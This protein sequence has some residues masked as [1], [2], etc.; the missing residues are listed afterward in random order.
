[1]KS[2]LDKVVKAYRDSQ[3]LN[4][5]KEEEKVIVD[6]ADIFRAEIADEIE[7]FKEELIGALDQRVTSIKS[8]DLSGIEKKLKENKE[9]RPKVN[10]EKLIAAI[11]N[12]KTVIS[13]ERVEGLTDT[14]RIA[15]SNAVP[16]TTTFVNGIRAKNLEF[17]TAAVSYL[18]DKAIIDTG[19]SGDEDL[20]GIYIVGPTGSGADYETDGTADDVQ[21]NEAIVAANLAGGGVVYILPGEYTIS[22]IIFILSNVKL[23]GSGI[24]ITTIKSV[25][26][27]N[28]PS[29]PVIGSAADGRIQL[30]GD[31]ATNIHISGITWDGN[32]QN[33]SGLTNNTHG[34]TFYITEAEDLFIK[35]NKFINTIHY[36][37]Y[38]GSSTNVWVENNIVLGG[39]DSTYV[40]ND[41]VLTQNCDYV[42][43]RG[44]FIDTVAGGG[45]SGDS[46]IVA[47]CT[48][49][50]HG[51][52]DISGNIISSRIAGIELVVGLD[53]LL[54]NVNV[55]DNTILY[56][57]AAGITIHKYDD[58]RLGRIINCTIDNNIIDNY[59][60]SGNGAITVIQETSVAEAVYEQLTITNNTC[61]TPGATTVNGIN[62]TAKGTSLKIDGNQ[63]KNFTG[64]Y[65]IVV[66]GTSR[67]VKDYSVCNNIID[68]SLGAS[69]GRGITVLGGERG[70]IS[71]NEIYGHTT[72]TTYAI[73]LAEGATAG[74]DNDGVPNIE[75][76]AYNIVSNNQIYNV[77]NGIAE[78]NAGG[79]P[80]DNQFIS[81]SFNTVTT[82]YTILS[83]TSRIFH[84]NSQD[85]FW[86]ANQV[87]ST[88]LTSLLGSG[89]IATSV[90]TGALVI[91]SESTG[92]S[93]ASA[94]ALYGLYSNDGAALASGDRMG[95]ILLGGSSSASS[96]RNSASVEGFT[97]QAWSDGSA[98]GSRLQFFTTNNGATSRTSKM[99]I[100]NDGATTIGTSL[101]TPI[102]IGGTGTTSTLTIQST[103]GAGTT[104]AD[105]L[106]K[107]GNN[108]ATEA[109]RI[110]NS[111]FFGIGEAAPQ[112]ILHVTG[113][114]A[115][116][117]LIPF[118]IKN[119][120]TSDNTATSIAFNNSTSTSTTAKI[121]AIRL[122]SSGNNDLVFSV[123]NS[124][125]SLTERMRLV[126]ASGNLKIAGTASRGTTEGT[127]QIVLFN[128]TAPAGTLTNGVSI[129]S[130]TGKLKSA[131]AAGT[132]GHILSGSAVNSVSPT[133]PNRTITVDI[134]G[135]TYYI[136][137]KTT[138]D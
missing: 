34:R 122:S 11:N 115:G 133:S 1:M 65:G 103:S 66:G 8:V 61:R 9:N 71:N 55:S 112:N 14:E 100:A 108:G 31:G 79:I 42:F 21:I 74:N 109:A 123:N 33:I 35:N 119:N 94:G 24:D 126:G 7:N 124:S 121:Q 58:N 125:A 60:I 91:G 54:R 64:L 129:Y 13:K 63:F 99:T 138:N 110:L 135:T 20:Q 46:C 90:V 106:F 96:I 127:N 101:T 134:G 87:P 72:G 41:G 39:Y 86:I 38:V 75:T 93:G 70:I 3:A 43:I 114:N 15:K 29:T 26:N 128:A 10:V 104:N 78:I 102:L 30:I 84:T 136:H 59:G 32:V 111:G 44:N 19:T 23:I 69:S 105:I 98:Y 92:T 2:K 88:A 16:P 56:A 45:T 76:C 73:Y 130:D 120:S 12:A 28:P 48:T 80:S 47:N 40:N 50:D 107:V 36:I 83:A 51:N 22:D 118:R 6:K 37:I 132:I 17:P 18:G 67:P 52:Y 82:P 89:T 68:F 25:N 4:E 85:P 113:T 81:N 49:G 77:V 95:G 137:A 62:C 57:R 117:E 116:A 5:K 97:E 27:Y 53:G 131:D